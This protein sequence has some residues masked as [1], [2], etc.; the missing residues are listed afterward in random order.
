MLLG[1]AL[2]AVGPVIVASAWAGPATQSATI[3]A[4]AT[5]WSLPASVGRFDRSLGTLA[6]IGFGLTGTLRGTIGVESL[7]M[8]PSAVNAGITSTISLFGPG[9]SPAILS[10][11]PVVGAGAVLAPF[12]GRIDFTG[13]SGRTFS[14]LAATQ[15]AHTT[16]A[17]GAAGSLLALAPFIGTGTVTLPVTTAATASLAGPLGLAARM[18]A[19]AGAAVAVEYG[20]AASRPVVDTGGGLLAGGF[21]LGMT[22]VP[23][24]GAE[25][26][27]AQTRTLSGEPG[28]WV[29]TVAFDRFDR[30]LGTLVSADIELSG[31]AKTRLSVRN[32]GAGVGAYDVDRMVAFDLRR[33]DGA[34]LG[35][36]SAQSTRSGT[37]DSDAGT[38]DFSRPFGAT[39]ADTLLA[40]AVL[41]AATPAD[42]AL[43][44]GLGEVSL[45]LTAIGTLLADLPGNADLLS[46]AIE[47]AILTLSYTY[48]PG[49]EAV[50]AAAAAAP[51]PG[52]L[53]LLACP[54]VAVAALLG[55]ARQ[56][57][58]V[59]ARRRRR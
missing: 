32:T 26:T 25:H 16:Y 8:L 28:D 58:R 30:S 34:S 38:Q 7:D 12:D 29:R 4:T 22:I 43:F 55:H 18:R 24:L 6:S 11:A 20:A 59:L 52:T 27:A 1:S 3:P 42:L 46:S 48:L 50:G 41:S 5:D 47:S 21:T 56:P 39:S 17:A 49:A 44:S 23:P 33:P 31:T 54:L 51:E 35:A 36:A 45:E 13:A 57:A 2:A 14:G 10:V 40:T 37:L 15:S 53:A 9:G 19:A